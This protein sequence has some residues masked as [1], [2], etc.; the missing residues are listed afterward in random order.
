MSLRKSEV[1][2]ATTFAY[3]CR[4]TVA[5]N[6]KQCREQLGRE[7]TSDIECVLAKCVRSKVVVYLWRPCTRLVLYMDL[8]VGKHY[9]AQCRPIAI[10]LN[11]YLHYMNFYAGAVE[12]ERQH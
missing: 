8:G 4:T 7:A 9:G 5:F 3:S 6:R 10:D 2:C 12:T 1:D 11:V